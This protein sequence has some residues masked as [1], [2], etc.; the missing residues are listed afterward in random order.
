MKKTTKRIAVG[1]IL[2][3]AAGYAAGI[4]TAPKSG[5][6]TRKDLQRAA[7][8]AKTEAEKN[9]KQSLHELNEL[10]DKGKNKAG[11]ASEK[12]KT[13]L[14]DSIALAKKAKDKAREILSAVHEGDVEDKDLKKA[15]ADAKKAISHLKKYLKNS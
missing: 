13:E 9:L 3:A 6:E 8:K 1:T 12:A 10:I 7:L 5:K 15:V 2:A 11:K 14:N 4:L